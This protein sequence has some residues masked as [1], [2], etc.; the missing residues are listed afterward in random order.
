MPQGNQAPRAMWARTGPLGSL[1]KRASLVCKA[2]QDSPGQRAP[3]VTKVKMEDQGTLD[4]EE[5]WASKVRQAHLD[6]LVSWALRERQEKWDLWVKG[7]LRAPLDLLVNK[8][9]L[10]WKAEREPRGN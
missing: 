3:L 1:E 10:A 2:L 6:Q 4:R 5:N 8:V 9:F 7:G